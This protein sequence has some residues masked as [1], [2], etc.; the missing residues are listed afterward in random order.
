MN[1]T[2]FPHLRSV[3]CAALLA[4]MVAP[5]LPGCDN[6]IP[7]LVT[8]HGLANP[9]TTVDLV[10]TLAGKAQKNTRIEKPI[11]PFVVY[12]PADAHGLLQLD[13]DGQD[14][15]C[16]VHGSTQLAVTPGAGML[17]AVIEIDP[18]TF[19]ECE[20]KVTVAGPGSIVA[21]R[22]DF[23]RCDGSAGT[24]DC[25]YKAVKG[26]KITL[27]GVE[28]S[29][30]SAQS[31]W[32]PPCTHTKQGCALVM[33]RNQEVTAS[34]S[35]LICQPGGSCEWTPGQ[36]APP[37]IISSD[38]KW[39]VGTDKRLRT[40]TTKWETVPVSPSKPIYALWSA[41]NTAWA[42]TE[43][44]ILVCTAGPAPSCR[45]LLQL[46]TARTI[47]GFGGDESVPPRFWAAYADSIYRC[48]TTDC[49][50]SRVDQIPLDLGVVP[51]ILNITADANSKTII[52]G[53][54]RS[55]DKC[56]YFL[57]RC[58]DDS[59]KMGSEQRT[60]L[61]PEECYS[62]NQ[63]R[64]RTEVGNDLSVWVY[65]P[66]GKLLR[67]Q[68]IPY[69]PKTEQYFPITAAA[70]DKL[71]GASPIWVI[72]AAGRVIHGTSDNMDPVPTSSTAN[73]NA[74]WIDSTRLAWIVGDQGSMFTADTAKVV[75]KKVTQSSASFDVVHGD[76]TG[77]V[78]AL[79]QND[80]THVRCPVAG[81]CNTAERVP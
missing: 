10:P 80:G 65:S 45:E 15:G 4:A 12:L 70:F 51:T 69:T 39:A 67:Y 79:S 2:R 21:D 1:R 55:G 11:E 44:Q 78:W 76:N 56:I 25:T 16:R 81:D 23:V 8:I 41:G 74:I 38:G 34:F 66:L 73:L 40:W 18:K 68:S 33:D 71:G 53:S 48:S 13:I 31:G 49:K 75:R 52:S 42:L 30:L 5:I 64:F 6:G 77:T 62:R 19:P 61:K 50:Q 24:K 22:P 58:S 14:G 57:K 17:Q 7:V 27:S 26:T 72:G 29:S 47:H 36:V 60:D 37:R 59:C 63:F 3:G 28:Q 32:A 20:L 43:K 35:P 46:P 54:Y 9:Q